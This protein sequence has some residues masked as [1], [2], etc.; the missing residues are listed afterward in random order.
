MRTAVVSGTFDPVTVGHINIIG[1][2]CA[3]FDKV[4]VAVCDSHYKTSF[5]SAEVRAAALKASVGGFGNVEVEICDCLL[6][7]FCG[8]YES[9]VI[10]RG[11]RNGGDFEYE[12]EM[13]SLNREI[14]NVVNRNETRLDSV[15]LPAEPALAH[16]SSSFVRELIKYGKDFKSAVPSEAYGIIK[17]ALNNTNEKD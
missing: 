6:A 3:L 11:A 7:D 4:V 12:I 1:R 16:I 5:F 14:M 17:E 13:Y 15:V 9:P 10:V 2:A 8:R